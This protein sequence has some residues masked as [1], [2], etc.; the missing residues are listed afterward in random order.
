MPK[1]KSGIGG[2]AIKGSTHHNG[3]FMKS[4]ANQ[5]QKNE[6]LNRIYYLNKLG[7]EYRIISPANCRQQFGTLH[8]YC[9]LRW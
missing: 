4:M 2:L 6:A 9:H 8:E 5:R 7:K 3:N 1:I